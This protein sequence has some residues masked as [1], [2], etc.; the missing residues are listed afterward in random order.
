MKKV[1]IITSLAC[2][3]FS[4]C[5][6]NPNNASET[7]AVTGQK[8]MSVDSTGTDSTKA[9]DKMAKDSADAAHGHTH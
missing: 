3:V 8:S 4:A 9:A 1:V 7:P 2:I 5:S 6:N